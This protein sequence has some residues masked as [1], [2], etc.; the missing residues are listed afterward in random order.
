VKLKKK[1]TVLACLMLD[2]G[3]VFSSEDGGFMAIGF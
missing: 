3:A 1:T 2:A